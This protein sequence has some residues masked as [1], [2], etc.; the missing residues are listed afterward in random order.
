MST[1]WCVTDTAVAVDPGAAITSAH[2]EGGV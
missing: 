2:R 1:R